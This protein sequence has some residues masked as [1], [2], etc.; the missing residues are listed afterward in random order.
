MNLGPREELSE[1]LASTFVFTSELETQSGR[2]LAR[3][4]VEIHHFHPEI[5][6]WLF[7]MIRSSLFC[8][9]LHRTDWT[10]VRILFCFENWNNCLYGCDCE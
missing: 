9:L 5:G 7:S 10:I 1:T 8:L 3:D 4:A 2:L 6:I